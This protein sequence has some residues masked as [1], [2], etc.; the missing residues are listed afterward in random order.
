MTTVETPVAEEAVVPHIHHPIPE[1]VPA[2]VEARSAAAAPAVAAVA[3]VVP[4]AAA[5]EA[6]AGNGCLIG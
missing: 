3:A 5:S 6:D 4:A 2:V 1:A